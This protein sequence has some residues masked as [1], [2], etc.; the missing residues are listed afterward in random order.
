MMHHNRSGLHLALLLLILGIVIGGCRNPVSSS[1]LRIAVLPILDTL[2]LYVAEEENLFADHNLKVVLVPVASAA[3][4]DQLLQTGQVDGVITDL[5]ALAMY[6]R[7]GTQVVAVRYALRP[8]PDL[9][10]FRILAAPQSGITSANDLRSTPIGLSQ[11]TVVEYVA[12]RLLEAEGLTADEITPLA[13]PKIPDRMALLLG[14]ELK[15]AVLPEPLASLAMQHGATVVLDDRDHPQFSGSLYAFRK[16]IVENRPELIRHFLEAI[17]ESCVAI[18]AD[19]E[20]WRGLLADKHLLPIDLVD[21]YTLP[22]YPTRESKALLPS[23]EQFRDVLA[24]LQE[25]GAFSKDIAPSLHILDD[26][27]LP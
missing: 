16:E 15:V 2:P 9:P 13:V 14:G 17:E 27:L 11:G 7:Q 3:E 6:N 10:Q 20:K 1:T 25:S 12:H 19:K 8:T 4:R 24:W 21:S 23:E 18:N 26:S 22:D 5:V